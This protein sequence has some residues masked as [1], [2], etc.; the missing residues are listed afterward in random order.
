[1]DSFL[2]ELARAGRVTPQSPDDD[3][4]SRLILW[5][6]ESLDASRRLARRHPRSA[7]LLAYL[8]VYHAVRALL[9]AKGYRLMPPGAPATAR[10][11]A[12]QF[13]GPSFDRPLGVFD[14]LAVQWDVTLEN[15]DMPDEDV[16]VSDAVRHAEAILAGMKKI[17]DREFP[18]FRPLFRRASPRRTVSPER[19]FR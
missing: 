1:M 8:A 19:S 4:A 5:S 9:S 3:L 7:A 6:Q 17:F 11:A 15:P 14:R 16:P 12:G 2:L 10:R 18:A 13:L